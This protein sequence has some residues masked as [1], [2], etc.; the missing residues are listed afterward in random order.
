MENRGKL[1]TIE[2]FKKDREPRVPW[3]GSYNKFNILATEINIDTLKA[4][5][6]N[7]T[8]SSS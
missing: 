7:I 8:N 5:G 4:K 2:Q 3:L 6:S 1:G